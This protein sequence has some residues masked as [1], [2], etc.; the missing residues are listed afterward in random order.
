MQN[1][2]AEYSLEYSII[3]SENHMLSFKCKGKAEVNNMPLPV[4]EQ[5]FFFKKCGLNLKSEIVLKESPLRVPNRE[6]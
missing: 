3:R 4:T 6:R 1:F 2:K 5:N